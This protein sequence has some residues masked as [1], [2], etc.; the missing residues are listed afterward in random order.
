MVSDIVLTGALQSTL[1]SLQRT[2]STID[3]ITKRLATGKDVNSALDQP[4][5]FFSAQALSNRAADLSRLLD[6]VGQSVRTIEEAIAGVDAIENLIDQA[7]AVATKS[8][9]LLTS[10]QTDPGVYTE[11]VQLN[12]TPL[13]SQI[14]AGLPDSYFRLNEGGGPAT[15]S[16]F[17]PG[18]PVGTQ[19]FGGASFGAAS[20]QV[21]GDGANHNLTGEDFTS[22]VI[23]L[24]DLVT[25][26]PFRIGITDPG[27]G[28]VVCSKIAV[29]ISEIVQGC[30]SMVRVRFR[31]DFT[32]CISVNCRA[33]PRQDSI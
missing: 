3:T 12:P 17:H 7:E 11:E 5:N 1:L 24:E 19:S 8:K 10:G 27:N 6:G 29:I 9:E 21:A 4:Q 31:R 18:A 33:Q 13:S 32:C 14:L 16:G 28:C 26:R 30:F 15:D 22:G 2:Q 20:T 25:P 23:N